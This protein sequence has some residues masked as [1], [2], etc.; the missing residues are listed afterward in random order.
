[1][2]EPIDQTTSE[3]RQYSDYD[4][5]WK[6]AL[7][8]HLQE[9]VEKYFPAIHPLIDWTREPVWLD[10]EISQIIGQLGRKNQEVDLLF[11]VWRLDGREQWILC[12]LEIQTSY[13]ADFAFRLDLYNAALKGQFRQEVLTFVILAD[14][15]P[16]WRP[17]EYRFE[18]GGF[19]SY[20]RFPVCKVLD[21]LTTD[22][23]DDV[24]LSVQVARAQIAA[25][26]TAGDPD[27]RF[28]VKTQMVRNLYNAGYTADNIREIFRLIDWMMHLRPDLS[29]RFD[30]ELIAYEEELNMPYITSVERNATERGLE[31]GLEQGLER[32]LKEGTKSLLLLQLTRVCGPLPGE[33]EQSVR[34]LSVA[35][36][37]EL[38]E[39]LLEFES[40]S[41]LQNWLEKH[42]R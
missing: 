19:E 13:E 33:I 38:G 1:M 9:F 28:A 17:T 22:W 18:F 6:E 20:R 40:L 41:D 37:Q 36:L 31:Q 27:A 2:A 34:Q 4:G 21:H 11:Q 42:T 23:N 16:E 35:Q 14:L 30:T 15:K 5:A 24:S 3:D 32:G 8:F 39:S 7:R 26:Q 25:L 10:K 29:R 12:H